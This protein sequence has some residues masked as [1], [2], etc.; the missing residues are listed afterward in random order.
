MTTP[1]TT[2]S[3]DLYGEDKMEQLLADTCIEAAELLDVEEIELG[4][5]EDQQD[6]H[7][8][9]CVGSTPAGRNIWVKESTR[10]RT[11]TANCVKVGD[12]VISISPVEVA[13]MTAMLEGDEE[14]EITEKTARTHA[15]VQAVKT[16]MEGR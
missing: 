7:D 12:K 8:E 15:L 4:G 13:S 16:A 9:V 2:Q 10:T 5:S 6:E 3:F 14:T 11:Y 1:L